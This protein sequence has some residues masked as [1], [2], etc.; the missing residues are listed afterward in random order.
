VAT[1]QDVR[2]TVT[3]EDRF[4]AT[5]A[6]L[7]KDLATGGDELSRIAGTAS[8]IGGAVGVAFAS[9]GSVAGLKQLAQD[10]DALNDAG[11]ALGDSIENISALED[12]ARR[13]G[14]SLE[15]VVAAG[16]RL[17][18]VLSE[19][20]P[21]SPMAQALQTI[22]LSAE[23]LRGQDTTAALQQ[24]AQ[25]LSGYQ[26]DANKAR[27]V[28]DLF[29][30]SA[31]ELAPFLKDVADAGQLNATVTREQAEAAER[32]NKNLAAM[33]TAAGNAARELAGPMFAAVNQLFDALAGRGVGG[34]AAIDWY[35]T[36]PLQTAAVIGANVAFVMRGIG[37]EIGG[38]AAQAAALARGDFGGARTIGQA[39]KEDAKAA[40]EEF[41]RLET[42][43]MSI[44]RQLP[45]AEYSNEGRSRGGALQRVPDRAA[46]RV[47]TVS[48]AAQ[49]SEAERYLEQLQKQ[50]DKLQDLTT[51][52]QLLADLES[53]RIDGVTPKLRTQ[54]FLEA[55]RVD[56]LKDQNKQLRDQQS[57]LDDLVAQVSARSSELDSILE[58]TE[59]GQRRRL[60][61]QI[62]VVVRYA[63]ANEGNEVI[64]R[65]AL[66]AVDE[67]GKRLRSIGEQPQA[68]IEEVTR[69]EQAVQSFAENS[70]D[71]IAD[72]ATT[73]NGQFD[74]LFRSLRRDVLRA[75]IEDPIRDSMR[76]AVNIIKRELASVDGDVGRLLSNLLRGV[77]SALGFGVDTVASSGASFGAVAGGNSFDLF[78]FTGR[79]NG[80]PVRAGQLVRWQENGREW[81]VPD[82][83]G[84]VVT[85]QQMM[86]S[87]GGGFVQENH[88]HISGNDTAAMRRELQAAL[89]E[90]DAKLMRSLR[91][92]RAGAYAG[93]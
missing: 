72:F 68:V 49:I 22:G 20:K 74:Q 52:Q 89:E 36:V 42:R 50:Q 18:K 5:F 43:L 71:A 15:L 31:R 93:V 60:E 88:F 2:Y 92:G 29:G 82:K 14:E 41:D 77:G 30:R 57:A 34:R 28:Q 64:E 61:R 21:D 66:A 24:V 4:S 37:T 8:R 6:R 67:L 81:F 23:Q 80:G 33:Q 16:L 13:N 39:M 90:R 45:Q 59:G 19:A 54:L 73:G 10:L 9:L 85:E 35:L 55:A 48:A 46:A 84:R 91:N 69:L 53:R 58:G 51:V 11:D 65:Q 47:P 7:K 75:I 3:A 86:G 1:D 78:G 56:V 26:D 63:Q 62:D 40:R 83:A 79:A 17:N 27:L 32:F 25:A 87:A 70:I 76:S 44:G 12:V 38:I